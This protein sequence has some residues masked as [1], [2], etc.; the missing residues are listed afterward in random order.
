M[1]ADAS[2]A[3]PAQCRARGPLVHADV[4]ATTRFVAEPRAL[5]TLVVADAAGDP[6]RLTGVAAVDLD[7]GGATHDPRA[8]PWFEPAS[9]PRLAL[10][11]GSWIA[12]VD[13]PGAAG[14]SRVVLWRGGD[15]E[16]LGEGDGFEGA[17][18]ACV[19][20]GCALLTTRIARVA[21]PGATVWFGS[22]SLPASR[23]IPIEI[24]PPAGESDARPLGL[25][26]VE[27]DSSIDAGAAGDAGAPSGAA[28]S[29][30]VT[31]ALVDRGQVVFFHADAAG[32]REIARVPAPH[33]TMD[34]IALPTPVAMSFAAPVD[35]DGCP[36]ERPPGVRFERPGI[37]A[38]E[39]PS[40]GQPAA[41]Y[42]RRLARG[43][44]AVWIT[45]LGCRL[46]RRVVHA[47]V[48]DATGTPIGTPMPVGDAQ[49]FA[50]ATQGDD[51][52]LYLQDE[53]TVTWARLTCAL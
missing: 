12:A 29:L 9:L 47:V 6:V 52:D 51:V 34:A 40:A 5:A 39:F 7:P 15:A 11:S 30:R 13:R 22:P 16:L 35:D 20:P 19:A 17:A 28:G 23:W 41:G 50:V 8:L 1:R 46:A 38:V 14:A 36:R 2:L 25:A 33:G 10:R 43:A 26:A 37:A 32:A 48:L 18:L 3:F 27:A 4:A 53:T 31:A 49:S 44:L 21:Q 45:P 24:V 42:L